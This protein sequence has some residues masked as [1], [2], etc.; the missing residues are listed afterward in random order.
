MVVERDIVGI[1]IAA[2]GIIDNATNEVLVAQNVFE[3]WLGT[4]FER[5]YTPDAAKFPGFAPSSGN[6]TS[7][8]LRLEND[9]NCAFLAVCSLS[10]LSMPS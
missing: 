1:G 4:R 2:A 8:P 5:F 6:K 9:G 3:G 7:L 10:D